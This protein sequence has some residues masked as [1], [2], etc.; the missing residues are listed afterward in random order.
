M[1]NLYK[2][3]PK[4]EFINYNFKIINVKSQIIIVKD[5]QNIKD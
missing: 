4:S 1:H 2:L 3:D 5:D